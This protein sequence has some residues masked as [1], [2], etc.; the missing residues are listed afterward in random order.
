MTRLRFV[1]LFLL[2]T[3]ASYARQGADLSY[4]VDAAVREFQAK[5]SAP[6]VTVA[7][8]VDGKIVYSKAFGMADIENDVRA[9]P[10]TLIRTGSIAKPI[11]AVAALT[12]VDAGKLDLDAPIQRYCPTFPRKQWTITTRE[13]LGH[14]SG[15]RHYSGD[16]MASTKHYVSMSEGFEIFANDPL[17][18]EPGTKY[19]YSTYG[20]TVV[21]CVIE[22]ASGQ[23]F[24]DYV[25]Q[26][27]LQ[28]AGMTHT[29]ID[30]VYTIVPHRARGYQKVGGRV[31]NAGLMDSSYKLP[32]GGYVSTAE[33]LVRFQLALI[34]GRIVNRATRTAM[35]TSQKTAD[36][37]LT[38]YGM[39]FGINEAADGETLVGHNG[40]QQGTSTSMMA[41]PSRHCA[42]AVMFNMDGVNAQSLVWTILKLYGTP[43]PSFVH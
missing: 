27:V 33:D 39:G 4:R 43:V 17:L 6:A 18:F 25:A 5:T 42:V 32:G 35:W 23:R 14:L 36:G 2:L 10:E 26:H 38:H 1:L 11:A 21:G 12:L 20:F 13:L 24:A 34:N 37:K 30:D 15:I 3:C 29:S 31:E 7:V 9:T 40:S 16:E 28:P 41:D 8:A 19:S 22:G